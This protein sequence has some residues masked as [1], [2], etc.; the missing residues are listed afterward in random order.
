[1]RLTVDIIRRAPQFTNT[2]LQRE[3]DLRGLGLTVLDERPLQLLNDSFDVLNLSQNPLVRLEYF[4]SGI[5]A[6]TASM[7]GE[8]VSVDPG[9]R[10]MLRLQSLIVHR[11]HLSHVS[12]ATCAALLPNMRAFLADY[13]DFREL[14]DLLFLSH[15]RQLEILSIEHNPV[16]QRESEVRLRAFV[17]FICPKLKL[18]NYQRVTQVDRRN[19]E[20]MREEFEQIMKEWRCLGEQSRGGQSKNGECNDKTAGVNGDAA[21]NGRRPRK[22]GREARA[23]AAAA[24]NNFSS[25]DGF[26]EV[27]S[28][29]VGSS[30]TVPAVTA[31]D[32]THEVVDSTQARLVAL[33]AKMSA[34][35]TEEELL[36]IQQEIMEL[37][38]AARQQQQQQQQE[39][40][41]SKRA[42][43]T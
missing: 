4:P 9:R 41:K 32:A 13:N 26:G 29:A 25:G 11:N 2:L 38:A 7:A 15:W 19:V 42:R 1:M 37:E 30:T 10:M 35:E 23:A 12:E 8:T 22:R 24:A 6:G 39:G 20:T 17:V 21:V 36:E 31:S 33:E 14:R 34:A 27:A 28:A 3:I 40:A 16:T 43:T 18:V 5:G